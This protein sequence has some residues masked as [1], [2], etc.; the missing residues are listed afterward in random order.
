MS[1]SIWPTVARFPTGSAP[2]R[3]TSIQTATRARSPRLGNPPTSNGTMQ[4]MK[5]AK[6]IGC[7]AFA[8][9]GTAMGRLPRS[10]FP[11]GGQKAVSATS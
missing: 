8:L 6:M 2:S 11:S 7:I 1:F 5:P 10:D 4:R 3:T 9:P